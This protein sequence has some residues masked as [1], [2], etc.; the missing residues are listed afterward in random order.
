MDYDHLPPLFNINQ[1]VTKLSV[2]PVNQIDSIRAHFFKGHHHT[3]SHQ[4]RR[5]K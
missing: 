5:K 1:Q 3:A 2:I 4:L